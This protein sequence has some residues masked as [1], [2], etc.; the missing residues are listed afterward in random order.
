[1]DLYNKHLKEEEKYLDK[2]LDFIKKDMKSKVGLLSDRKNELLDIRKEMWENTVH[3]SNDFDKLTEINQ[4]LSVLSTQ[5]ISYESAHKQIEKYKKLLSSPYFGRFDFTEDNMGEEKIYVGLHNVIDPQ[6]YD[7]LVY[8]W[9]SPISSIFYQYELGDA[10]YKAPSGVIKGSVLLK[11]QYKIIEGKLKYFFDCNIQINDEMLQQVLSKNSSSKMKNIVETIQKEQDIIIRDIDNELLIVQGIA[12]SGKTSIALHRIAFLLYHGISSKLTSNNII[13][14]SPNE[15]FSKYISGVLPE[16]G[17]ENVNQNTFEALALNLIAGRLKIESRF[18]LLEYLTKSENNDKIK[19]RKS[20]IDFK[21]SRVCAKILDRLIKYYESNMVEFED[22]YYDG[23][24]I[25]TKQILKNQFL[26]DKIGMPI[27]KRLKRMERMILNKIH[28]IQ[29]ER[30]KKIEKLVQK[31]G[32][33]EFEIKSFSRLLS[34]KESRLL[35]KKIRRFTEID[36]I[37]IYNKLFCDKELFLKLSKGLDLP[38]DIEDIIKI[39]ADNIKKGYIF[40]EDCAPLLFIKL[41]IEGS[42]MFTQIRQVVVDEAQDYSCLEYEVFNML[43]KNARFTVV[44]D[45]NQ[46][47]DKSFNISIYDEIEEILNKRKSTKLFL[48]KGYRSSYEI[49]SFAQKI[50]NL[51]QNHVNLERYG[52]KPLIVHKNNIEDMDYAIVENIKASIDKGY[53]S[54]AII[55]KTI[56]ESKEIYDRL[57][58]LININLID[59]SEEVEKGVI[60]I[61]AYIAKGLEFDSVFVYNVSD[62]N[63]NCDIHKKLFYIAC[64]R[65][66]HRLEVYYIGDKSRFIPS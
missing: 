45:I 38:N 58:N 59:S 33:H 56:R 27:S 12:G 30:V 61:P 18:Q 4:Y 35:L 57:K 31:I 39:T 11:R 52:S 28:P 37:E 15:V 42:D 6:T 23:L 29:R 22:V 19:L 25:E 40:Y 65:A 16:L 51:N 53:K 8:D 60:I 3:F 41:K 20:N 32:G 17:E 62:D 48:S 50:L 34:V 5:T 55:C 64:T 46:T 24:V 2:T 7:I 13:I 9:R 66:L 43:F 63:Y 44:G 14:V 36:Y 10:S 21:G 1:M 26:S 47:I 54:I 49:S